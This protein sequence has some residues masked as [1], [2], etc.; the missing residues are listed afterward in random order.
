[1]SH[2]NSSTN[3]SKPTIKS[4]T[5]ICP[6]CKNNC[7]IKSN[8]FFIQS[9][10]KFGHDLNYSM[11]EFEQGQY[12]P[13]KI[14]KCHDNC[15]QEGT[16]EN[17]FYCFNC[18]IN[19]CN[20]CKNHHFN[21]E[22]EKNSNHT[23]VHYEQ[24]DYLCPE[25]FGRFIKYCG[26]CDKNICFECE[27]FHKEHKTLYFDLNLSK[28][29][30]KLENLKQL[31]DKIRTIFDNSMNRMNSFFYGIN[32]IFEII[33]GKNY[34][35]GKIRTCQELKNLNAYDIDNLIQELQKIVK[36]YNNDNGIITFFVSLIKLYEKM[37][38]PN[39]LNIINEKNTNISITKE[40]SFQ[41]SG[42]KTDKKNKSI[43]KI[44]IKKKKVKSKKLKLIKD[45]NSGSKKEIITNKFNQSINENKNLRYSYVNLSNS[46]L[47]SDNIKNKNKIKYDEIIYIKCQFYSYSL[48]KYDDKIKTL[49]KKYSIIYTNNIF[50]NRSSFQEYINNKKCCL[51][52]LNNNFDNMTSDL[53]NF[54][55]YEI[56][57]LWDRDIVGLNNY[58][59]FINKNIDENN[60]IPELPELSS[61][62]DDKSK[63]DEKNTFKDCIVII[64]DYK[65]KN[66]T[67]T[68]NLD[69]VNKEIKENNHIK[70][71]KII[72]TNRIQ[73]S[74]IKIKYIKL[75]LNNNEINYDYMKNIFNYL[76][77]NDLDNIGNSLLYLLS[78]IAYILSLDSKYNFNE[79]VKLLLKDIKIMKYNY[80]NICIFS[81]I[82]EG[83]NVY[84]TFLNN[85]IMIIIRGKGGTMILFNYPYGFI[86][87]NI[88][89]KYGFKF[90]LN[91]ISF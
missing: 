7:Q 55:R 39:S 9:K 87:S 30:R 69:E 22:L 51:S 80:R 86:F 25:H 33:Y 28:I 31:F 38:N 62:S 73:N 57:Y 64:D 43:S 67:Y 61:I 23:V 83:K 66:K 21:S 53:N 89:F 5:A 74:L 34:N 27:I 79:V 71:K 20:Y 47:Y 65:E 24:K 77:T 50:S 36:N 44:I 63:S 10:C 6:Q 90:F 2:N 26:D 78:F 58:I 16:E 56:S 54:H 46:V 52:N 48:L 75:V 37:Y 15:Q 11:K 82:D 32:D 72:T 35:Y 3:F 40:N 59:N 49:F 60:E 70:N 12:R 18:K 68:V 91:S 76:S 41:I 8:G 42:K 19:L 84:I 17:F 4:Q 88:L 85:G 29:N 13:I 81:S 14:I 1:M 45:N